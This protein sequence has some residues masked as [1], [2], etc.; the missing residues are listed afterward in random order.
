MAVLTESPCIWMDIFPLST[1][2]TPQASS[3]RRPVAEVR[4][5]AYFP[6]LQFLSLHSITS[7][8]DH[9]LAKEKIARAKEGE[10]VGGQRPKGGRE[11]GAPCI[12]YLHV[13]LLCQLNPVRYIGYFLPAT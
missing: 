2:W 4:D 1:L 13:I 8:I 5:C 11:G 7:P 12:E 6:N 3:S 10:G 9:S